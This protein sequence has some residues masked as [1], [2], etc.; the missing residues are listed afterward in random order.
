MAKE[1]QE[2]LTVKKEEN[3]T[4]WF[5]Q[6]MLKAEVADYSSVSGC[7]VYRPLGFALWEKIKEEADKEFKKIGVKNTYFPL[8]IPESSFAKE[9]DF[10]KGFVK[11]D[12]CQW[13]D[14][15]AFG[16]WARIKESGKLRLEGKEYIVK[17][18]DVVEFKI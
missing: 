1:T 8:F 18:G 11:A 14:F 7:I 3:F 5:T 2:G 17:D 9:T 4:E 12:V 6:L 13:Q 10:V 15:V 16:G